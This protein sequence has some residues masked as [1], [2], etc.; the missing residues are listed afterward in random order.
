MTKLTAVLALPLFCVTARA[1]APSRTALETA[2]SRD[3]SQLILT[4]SGVTAGDELYIDGEAMRVGTATGRVLYVYR[5]ID[6]TRATAH[7]AGATVRTGPPALFVRAAPSGACD[8]V[9]TLL[10]VSTGQ[11]WSCGA[12]NVWMASGAQGYSV[13]AAGAKADG[14]C[15]N[16]AINAAIARAGVGGTVFFPPGMTFTLCGEITPLAGQ[17]LSGYGATLRRHDAVSTTTATSISPGTKTITVADASGFEVGMD[18]NVFSGSTFDST[19]N[20]TIA[21]I[22]GNQITTST[23]WN[24]T[25]SS[26]GTVFSSCHEIETSAAHVRILGLEFDGNRANNTVLAKWQI[27]TEIHATSDHLRIHDVYI[28]DAQSEGAELLGADIEFSDSTVIN[29]G[30]NCVHLGSTTGARIVDNY[31][32]TCNILGTATG[33]ADGAVTIS[34]AVG[35]TLVSGNYIDTAIAGV[36]SIDSTDNSDIVISGNVIK[37]MTG[38]AVEALV[39]DGESVGQITI[40]NNLIY[41]SVSII[42]SHVGSTGSDDNVRIAGNYLSNTYVEIG[43]GSRFSVVGNTI[44]DA[45]DTSHNA[46]SV[47]LANEV[48]I[49]NNH[50]RGFGWGIAVNS[51]VEA[52]TIEN[53]TFKNQYYRGVYLAVDSTAHINGNFLV[54]D[55]GVAASSYIG[56]QA[57]NGANVQNN[58]LE[59]SSGQY[60]ILSANGDDSVNGALISGNVIRGSGLTAS[61]FCFGG[62]K[63]NHLVD[64]FVQVAN[65]GQ[66]GVSPNTE[67]G[68]I[69]I[70]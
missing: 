13:V 65:G 37:N 9:D 67:S 21:S 22:S 24:V 3:A 23:A 27:N 57:S 53:N 60:G 2:I 5:G 70:Y 68:T 64:N 33:H 8:S 42:V 56:I 41:D 51:A 12:D 44:D 63:N 30:G 10:D 49:A 34:D 14:S 11:T 61:I 28:H 58:R 16:Q 69:T 20:R 62:T 26:G 4:D 1:A 46:I 47:D 52:L 18:I 45:A 15:A 59:L 32:Q 55:T 38:N 25:L 19:N 66:C 40:A 48:L 36:G 50:V 39:P 6:G 43:G 35:Y 54:T 7:N 17:T 29:A 31:F